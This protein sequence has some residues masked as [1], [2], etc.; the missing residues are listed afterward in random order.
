MA[1]IRLR[2]ASR[3]RDFDYTIAFIARGSYV[4]ATARARTAPILLSDAFSA[5]VSITLPS[6]IVRQ[7]SSRIG[8]REETVILF[9]DSRLNRL[10]Y[11][12]RELYRSEESVCVYVCACVCV[13]ERE[14]D[15]R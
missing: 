4:S 2:G 12:A 6:H 3:R 9:F 15:F 1:E 8:K 5:R 7:T 11:P 13:C 10:R 14:R